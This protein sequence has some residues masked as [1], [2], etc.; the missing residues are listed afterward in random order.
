MANTVI[1]LKYSN[2]TG[3]PPTLNVAEPAYSSVTGVLWIDDGTGVVPIGG[4]SYTDKI[5]AATSAA[6]GNTLVKRDLTGNASFNYLFANNISGNITGQLVGNANSATRLQ[7]PRYVN[8]TG[9]A[10]GSSIFDGT[11][12]ADI[13]LDLT[14]TGV[15]AGTY[16][17]STN[18]PTFT[19][20][21]EGRISHAANV[22]VA[23]TLTVNADSGS[24][25][26]DLLTDTLTIAG[27]AGITTS[28]SATDTISIDVDNTVVRSNTAIQN[29]TIDG[30]ITIT[31]NLIV[32]GNVT[33]IDV[34]TLS[35]EDSLIALA[36]NN[37]TDAV[38]IGFYGHYND[39]TNRHAGVYRHAGDK[40][41]Y[42]FDNYNQEP[43][44]NTLN[45]ADPSFR[46]ATLNTNLTS[47]T[48]NVNV[49]LTLGSASHLYANGGAYFHNSVQLNGG[50]N[51]YN[52]L[53]LQSANRVEFKNNDNSTVVD[54]YNA[55][56][57]GQE[58]LYFDSNESTFNGNVTTD[59]ATVNHSL[60][61]NQN[62]FVPNLP[63]A[64]TGNLVF[65]DTANGR[66]SYANDN[67]LT[68]TSIANG[69]YSLSISGTNGLLTTNGNGLQLHNGAVIKDTAGDAVAFGQNA[70]AISQGA[71]A[72]AIGDSA[73]YNAQGDF[74]VAI[75]Y[76]AGNQNQSQVAVA[77]GLNAGMTNQ[78]YNGIAIGNSA[79]TSQGTGAVALGYSSGGSGGNYS[80]AI[81]HEAAKGNT[82]SIGANAVA[83]GYKAGYESAVAGSIILNASGNNLSSAAAGFYVNPV[84]YTA[85]QDATYDGLMFFNSNTKEIRYS[86]VLNGGTF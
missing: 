48:A 63:N 23:T 79:G 85:T 2:V 72:V 50:A 17:G 10:T 42:V 74:A 27:G 7:T 8:I 52:Y 16:G 69:S 49:K 13:T 56:G 44:A 18:I 82:S 47:N 24:N 19:V 60:T 14:D 11:A 21:A 4:K 53:T 32:T 78:G 37:V 38:D 66:F 33:S 39:G 55:G 86:Y 64:V 70:G 36:K 57:A 5:D 28:V 43:A 59:G 67:T 68:P 25:S 45:P 31:G 51:L 61:V 83:I 71:Q 54:I 35:V 62:L 26:V 46:L 81:G 3:Q 29:Q 6:T 76:G 80:V 73:G 84:R 65:F 12:N 15:A 75:G 40:Q 41:F 9:D 30:T 34:T 77:I 58:N 1:Q 22:S 20:D